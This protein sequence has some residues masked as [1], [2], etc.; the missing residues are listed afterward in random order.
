MGLFTL[1]EA[2]T[3]GIFEV[4]FQNIMIK[5]ITELTEK[6]LR[7]KK[8]LLR[9]DFNVPI[10]NGRVSE[11]YKIKAHKETIEFLVSSGAIIGLISHMAAVDSFSTIFSQISD[12]LGYNLNFLNDCIGPS[13]ESSLKN[14]KSGDIFLLE[15]VRKHN[16]EEENNVEFARELSKSFD[17]YINNAF[18]ESHRKYASVASITQFLPPYAGLLLIKEVENLGKVIKLPKEKKTLIIGG[19]KVETK[20][21]V[22]KNFIDKAEN[23]LVGGAVANVF[24][25]SSGVDIKESLVDDDFLDESKKLLANPS[26]VV[27]EDYI[28]FNDMILDIGPKTADKFSEI[29]KNSETIIWNGPLGKIEVSE[30]S[31]GTKAVAEAI[32]NSGA[33]SVVGGGDTIA[34]IEKNNLVDRFNYVSVSGGAMLQFLAGNKLP[35]LEVLGY[36]DV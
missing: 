29:I 22:I 36:Y 32:I 8:V 26:I 13:V 9:I 35:G 6:D 14:A 23:I 15:N 28:F 3:S 20:F 18:S 12:I 4:G 25:K 19:A 7:R 11:T 2:R 24:L 30:L 16:G 31:S 17:L 1:V 10:E 27:P 21:P 33:F 5:S 34:F